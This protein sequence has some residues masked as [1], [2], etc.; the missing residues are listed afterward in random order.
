MCLVSYIPLKSGY[1]LS[2]NRDESPMRDAADVIDELINGQKVFYPGDVAG[3]SW[4]FCSNSMRIVCILNGAFEDHERRLPYRQS[5]G[6]VGKDFFQFEDAVEFFEKYSLINIE[7]FTMIIV[8][9]NSPWEFRWD[10]HKKYIE[11]LEP[12]D[13]HVWSSCTLYSPDVIK[14]RANALKNNLKTI[15][16]TDKNALIQAHL[17][18]DKENL[19]N[20]LYMERDEIVK[21]ISHTQ[22][23]VNNDRASMR[24][25]NLI[26]SKSTK[27]EIN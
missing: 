24:Y 2:S 21:T 7:P 9:D 10:G 26:G 6:L 3:G 23:I 15:D 14:M 20:G 11:H 12:G 4:I 18:R 22:V 17:S 5:R 1:V 8:E 25:D 16:I 19:F 13:I 27:L